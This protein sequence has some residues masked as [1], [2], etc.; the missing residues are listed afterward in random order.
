MFGDTTKFK[1]EAPHWAASV[2]QAE[3][4]GEVFFVVFEGEL[5]GLVAHDVVVAAAEEQVRGGEDD[6]GEGEMARAAFDPGFDA[7]REGCDEGEEGEVFEYGEG[8]VG[9]FA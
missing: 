7:E 2:A 6:G 5:A 4:H 3:S 9:L 8:E 1:H